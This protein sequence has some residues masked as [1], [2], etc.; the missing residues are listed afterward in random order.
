MAVVRMETDFGSRYS[1]GH[2]CKITNY[3]YCDKCGSF[4]IKEYRTIKTRA[5]I[6]FGLSLAALGCLAVW[7][8]PYSSFFM[9]LLG[10]FVIAFIAFDLII[11]YVIYVNGGVK[12]RCRKCGNT[13]VTDDNVLNYQE[14]DRS[15]V[16]VPE[17]LTCKHYDYDYA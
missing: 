9:A 8:M 2:F 11:T 4:S 10:C 14:E 7:Y 12:H 16:D 5:G 13:D 6:A 3:L 1:D 17:R 15:V